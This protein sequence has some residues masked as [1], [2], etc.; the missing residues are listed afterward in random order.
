MTNFKSK[1]LRKQLIFKILVI[2]FLFSTF[3][4]C[5]DRNMES[6]TPLSSNIERKIEQFENGIVNSNYISGWNNDISYSLDYAANK[7]DIWLPPNRNAEHTKLFIFIHGGSFITGD[8]RQSHYMNIINALINEFPNCAIATVNYRVGNT[9]LL[10]KPILD[11]QNAVHYI[12]EKSKEMNISNKD[13]ILVGESAGSYL[14]FF[15]AF[16]RDNNLGN[17]KSI[18]AVVSLC[19]FAKLLPNTDKNTTLANRLAI[20]ALS[21]KIPNLNYSEYSPIKRIPDLIKSNDLP[22]VYLFYGESD[23]TISGSNSRDIYNVIKT[24]ANIK[25]TTKYYIHSFPNQKHTMDM[26][27]KAIIASILKEKIKFN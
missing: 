10:D 8:K 11:I 7:F 22:E 4:S 5:F 25:D 20:Q 18:K 1:P 17:Y 26:E 24:N 2:I 23:E 16:R 13:V 12:I 14:A 19:G 21:V 6:A 27:T 3:I 15:E 9:M